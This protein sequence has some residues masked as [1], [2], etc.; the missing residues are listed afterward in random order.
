MSSEGAIQVLN[1][2]N[3]I[4]NV[5]KTARPWDESNWDI[6]NRLYIEGLSGFWVGA[7]WLFQEQGGIDLPF[8]IGVVPW[9]CGPGGNDSTNTLSTPE[10]LW[11]FI[12]SG[13]EDTRL[14]Y[15]VLFDWV[16]WYAGD[17]ALGVDNDW[18]RR[19]FM[20]ERNFDYATMMASKPGLDL[21]ES[22]GRDFGF[23]ISDLLA[24]RAAP[25]DIVEEYR[26]LFQQALD[27]F[28]GKGVYD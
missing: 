18:S 1:F 25:M 3:D 10:G 19:M 2:I 17:A 26:D 7:D 9:P 12:P 15:D 5:D 16:N 8:E 20:S 4:Y 27:R 6:N 28:F 21:W 24:G 22:L 14:V 23:G 13:V 11:Y